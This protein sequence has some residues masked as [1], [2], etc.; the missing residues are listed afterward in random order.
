MVKPTCEIMHRWGQAGIV[1][2]KLR[3]D[4]AGENIALEKRLKSESWK[5]LV[6][7]E[8]TAQDN[9]QQNSLAEVA[10]YALAS[11]AQAAM[12]HA[13]LPMEMCFQLFGEIFTTITMLDGLTIIEVDGHRKSQY[14]HVFT[15]KPKFV[16][17]LCKIG[18]A[19]TVKI[20]NDT[21]PKLQDHGIHCIFVGYAE[22]HLEGCY[23]MY[24]PATHRVCQSHDVV[25]LNRMFYEKCN[26]N[27]ELNTNNVI[28]GNWKNNGNMVNFD[29]LKW[30]RESLKTKPLQHSRKKRM[31]QY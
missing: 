19:G 31:T 13:N 23:R 25:W 12:H 21:T 24:D 29:L 9:L 11:K 27:S 4:N 14:E 28:V 10:F 30:G 5:N 3:M 20:T 8:Y 1:I 6:D 7:M 22:N 16:K 26:N 17:Y 2:K 15:K 18:E